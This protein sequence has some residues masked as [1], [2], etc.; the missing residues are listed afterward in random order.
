[1]STVTE[2]THGTALVLLGI[3]QGIVLVMLWLAS[4]VTN[5]ILLSLEGDERHRTPPQVSVIGTVLAK[6]PGR[7]FAGSRAM[8]CTD[9][10][11]H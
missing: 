1:M 7:S 2:G 6:R 3:F 9:R 11:D 5:G 8:N 10:I 4:L